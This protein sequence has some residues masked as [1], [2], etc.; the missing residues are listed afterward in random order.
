MPKPFEGKIG[1]IQENAIGSWRQL[2]E[3]EVILFGSEIKTNKC[4]TP[5]IND[6][7]ERAEKTASGKILAYVNADIIL[8][9]D[10]VEAVKKVNL[11]RFLMVG[12][13]HDFDFERKIDFKNSKWQDNLLKE[14]MP[15]WKIHGSTGIDYF[16]FPKG[17]FGSIPSFAI[18]RTFWDSWLVYKAYISGVPVIDATSEIKAIHQNHSYSNPLGM[19]G[20]WKGDE[21]K[22]NEKLA[23]GPGH[24]FAIRDANFF[25]E[26]GEIRKARINFYKIITFPFRNYDKFYNFKIILFP[27]WLMMIAWRQMRKI[28]WK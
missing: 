21:A 27:G 14:A 19:K 7:F 24:A 15:K 23:G 25:L 16:I 3:T 17:I 20:I 5:L 18:G 1:L 10:F 9:D 12:R 22:E 2:K 4:G 13:R 8:M 6:I 11:E 26:K 28:L